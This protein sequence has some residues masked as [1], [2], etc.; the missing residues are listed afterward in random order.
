MST[1]RRPTDRPYGRD[2]R[3]SNQPPL[4]SVQF[5]IYFGMTVFVAQLSRIFANGGLE[6]HLSLMR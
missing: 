5:G 6:F 1:L 3:Y 4:S 2:A